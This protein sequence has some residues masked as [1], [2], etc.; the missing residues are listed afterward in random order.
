[1]KV[2]SQAEDVRAH[3]LRPGDMLTSWWV[4]RIGVPCLVL[5]VV[6]VSKYDV[7]VT[8]LPCPPGE[9]GV[10][11]STVGRNWVFLRLFS[12]G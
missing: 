9:D 10:T 11:T 1:M 5:S 12:S 2:Q 4:A 3:E 7:R 8:V 6:P